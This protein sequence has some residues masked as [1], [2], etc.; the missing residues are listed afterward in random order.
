MT[1]STRGHCIEN[2]LVVAADDTQQIFGH[3]QLVAL[4]DGIRDEMSSL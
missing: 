1:E 3:C 4:L 2:G